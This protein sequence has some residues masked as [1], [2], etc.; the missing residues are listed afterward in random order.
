MNPYLS[1]EGMGKLYENSAVLAGINPALGH[2][3]EY[4]VGSGENQTRKDYLEVLRTARSHLTLHPDKPKLF[5]VGYG[6]GHFLLE[7]AERGWEVDGIDTSGENCR[8]LIQKR[9]L[10]VRHGTFSDFDP[11][12]NHY[13][14]VALWD[15]IEHTI[16]PRDFVRKAYEMLLPGGLLVLATPN[17]HGLLNRVAESLY[18]ISAG[19]VAFALRQLYVTEHVG[20]FSEPTLKKLVKDAGFNVKSKF[21][22]ETDLERYAFSDYLKVGLKAFFLAARILQMQNRIVLIAE[23]PLDR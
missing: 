14:L 10:T 1:D 23:R 18:Q 3:Y 6:T 17:I 7:A 11:P 13:H 4:R 12:K 5:E 16:H 2:Y 22:T 8:M 15:V 21:L 9:G 19:R 20:Y